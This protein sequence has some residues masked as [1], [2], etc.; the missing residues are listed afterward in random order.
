M[1][2]T[3][4]SG[5]LT[6]DAAISCWSIFFPVRN[7]GPRSL[8]ESLLSPVSFFS[9]KWSMMKCLCHNGDPLSNWP[10]PQLFLVDTFLL[11]NV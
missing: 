4:F 10:V 11:V 2:P 6:G 1:H 5:V 8:C 3:I 7:N 9:L